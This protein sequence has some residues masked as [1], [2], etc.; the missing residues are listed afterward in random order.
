MKIVERGKASRRLALAVVAS[1][2][3]VF[4][5]ASGT[6]GRAAAQ[7]PDGAPEVSREDPTAEPTAVH[8]ASLRVVIVRDAPVL[9]GAERTIR[10][11]ALAADGS[12][13]E[14]FTGS[15]ELHG[16]RSADGALIAAAGPFDRGSF[17]LE[18][19]RIVDGRVSAIYRSPRGDV[20]GRTDRR[21]FP[22]WF[23]LLPPLVA[24]LCAFLTRQVVPSL[25][26]GVWIGAMLTHGWNPI[27]SFLRSI[28]TYVLPALTDEGHASILV[29]SL[30]LA[31]MVGVI[32]ATGGVRGLV[33]S[34]SNRVRT[35]RA[36]QTTTALL[37]TFV[38]FDDYANCLI[39]G[40]TVRPLTDRL[41]IS[42][43]KLSFLID[44]TAA[45]IATI[46]VI[47]TWTAYQLG[48]IREDLP[49]AGLPGTEAYLFFLLAIPFSF[50]SFLM[51]LFVF[52]SAITGRDFGPM[53]RAEER[54]QATGA[55]LR[56]GAQPLAV[57]DLA[58][59][60]APASHWATAVVPVLS[61]VVFTAIGL[62]TT[63][64][65]AAV[66]GGVDEPSLREIIANADSFRALLWASFG[67]SIVAALFA[68]GLRWKV[69]RIVEAWIGGVRSLVL[70]AVILL[71]AWSVSAVSK[72][73]QAGDYILE[74]TSGSLS[75]ALVPVIAFATAGLVAFATGT[76]YGA[77]GILIPVL[78]PL[79]GQL[80][81]GAGMDESEILRICQ[82]SVIAILGGAVFGD[83]CSPISDTT[84]L[85]SMAAG[86]DHIDHVRT[87][88]PYAL[89]VAAVTIPCYILAGYGWNP[90]LVLVLHAAVV[91][92]TLF[93]F[94]R[95]TSAS[96]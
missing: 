94:G 45:P 1:L 64:Y 13:L 44:A 68:L 89:L 95:R 42:R 9:A 34:I 11:D 47:S 50:Y 53:R 70:A 22:R 24:I 7:E 67:A 25:F 85:S 74:L 33:E 90:F 77:M 30:S 54:A 16:A 46:G 82:A 60:E 62:Y 27:T 38:F 2:V 15:V 76:S 3:S 32:R 43:E 91:L 52:A 14:A 69:G 41:R 59:A 12:V 48:L 88:L 37:G 8:P 35:S 4:A 81:A 6:G 93:V 49:N 20:S 79:A 75:P 63:G 80:A 66:G 26:C 10:I 71:L 58:V 86:A 57:D 78:L 21:T 29:F 28:D 19:A 83:H 61:V 72:E 55:V 87:Q 18:N 73:L 96:G 5:F 65:E 31:G 92:V 23:V 51:L 39:V 17:T 36:G 56:D 40:N 84:V